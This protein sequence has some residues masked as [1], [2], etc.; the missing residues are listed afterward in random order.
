MVKTCDDREEAGETTK[1]V[2][3]AESNNAGNQTNV[4]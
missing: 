4:L 1:T 3:E 2:Q